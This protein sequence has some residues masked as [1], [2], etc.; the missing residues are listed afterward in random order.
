MVLALTS[1]E[2]VENVDGVGEVLE[3]EVDFGFFREIFSAHVV[4]GR[5]VG[6]VYDVASHFGDCF[7]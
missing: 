2:L 1:F 7:I 6:P 4:I 5:I 3:R